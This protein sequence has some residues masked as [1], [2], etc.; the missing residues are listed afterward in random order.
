MFQKSK[1]TNSNILIIISDGLLNDYNL[2]KAKKEI[3]ENSEKLKI[4]IISIYLNSYNKKKKIEYFIILFK[5]IL[6]KEQNF[7]LVYQVKLIIII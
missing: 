3:L 4:T 1:N 2:E 6:M 5:K 7:Y